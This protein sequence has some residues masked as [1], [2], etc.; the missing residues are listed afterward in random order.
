MTQIRELAS[1]LR[2]PEGPIAMPDGDIV[3]VEIAAQRLTRVGKDGRVTAI[4]NLG[5]GPNGAAIGPGG[6]CYVCNNGGLT[7][8]ERAGALIPGGNAATPGQIQVV[9]LA[10]GKFET[11]YDSCDGRPLSAPNDLVFDRHGGFWFTDHGKTSRRERVRG[12]L[13]YAKADGSSVKEVLLALD[14]PNGVGLSPD[15]KRV[16]VAETNP[17]RIWAFDIVAPGEIAKNPNAI[18]YQRGHL[19][20]GVPGYQL[21]DSL[22]VD[23]EGWVCVA[24]IHNGG[25]TAASPDGT[26]VTHTPLPDALVTNICFGGPGLRT[27]YATL[28]GT[29]KLVAFDWPRAGLALNYLNR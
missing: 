5:G 26:T 24:T 2:F 15:E 21:F 9:D 17:G 23:A 7:W 3:L 14:G 19:L 29:G 16:Y 13:Y 28:S 6:K 18:Y 4:A 25:I 12:S 22:A 11:L 10:T 1:G 8:H 27:A 20:A